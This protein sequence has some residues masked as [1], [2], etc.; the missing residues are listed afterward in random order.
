MRGAWRWMIR[1]I[2]RGGAEVWARA[3][4]LVFPPM[5]RLC[6]ASI[7]SPR[8]TDFFCEKCSE[9]L[10]PFDLPLCARCAHPLPDFITHVE[11]C[12]HCVHRDYP[13]AAAMAFGP[14]DGQLRRAIILAKQRRYE[15]LATALGHLLA[16]RLLTNWH[17]YRPEVVISMPMHW[18]RR[19]VRSVNNVERI[20][21]VVGAAY[22]VPVSCWNLFVK[23]PTA[24]QGT[25]LPNE[26]F[27]NVKDA[28]G[29]CAPHRLRNKRILLV[30]DVLT[31]G[32]TASAAARALLRAGAAEVRIAVVARALGS[33]MPDRTPMNDDSAVTPPYSQEHPNAPDSLR[34]P[35]V[36]RGVEHLG[37]SMEVTT[38]ALPGKQGSQSE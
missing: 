22:D 28:F 37:A 23:R 6:S 24:K 11:R 2:V 38:G 8:D 20:A 3:T 26:R 25:L 10:R 21:E 18:W 19:L 31:T 7:E 13:F 4:D 30:D 12:P 15:P 27:S 35:P 14:Y 34:E 36:V 29:V 9:Q 5:C 32:A 33:P 17:G 16:G 1:G